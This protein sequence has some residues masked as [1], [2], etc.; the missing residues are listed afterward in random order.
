VA[1]K[2]R[3]DRNVY[4]AAIERLRYVFAENDKVVVSFSGGKDST[5][6]AYLAIEVA[7]ELKRPFYLF[8]LDQE[9]EYSSTTNF[10]DTM[11]KHKWVIPLWFQVPCLLTNTSSMTQHVIDPWNPEKKNV[12]IRCQKQK[13]TTRIDW[14]VSGV[15][16]TF[17]DRQMYGFYGLV[18]CM[19]ALFKE[20]SSVAQVL[21][22]RADESLDRFRAVTKNPGIPGVPWST[23]GHHHVKFYP[24]YDWQFRDVW[25]Y[26]G[27]NGLPYNKMYDY[28]YL[29]GYSSSRMRLSN[30]LHEKAY[31]CIADLQEFEPK[32]YDKMIDRCMGI[33]TA[34]EY[35]GRGGAIYHA[36][37]LPVRFASWVEYRD[38]LLDT[39]PNQEHAA[40]FRQ[41]FDKQHQNDYVVRQQ[42]NRVLIYDIHN[43]KKINN[44][45]HD[46]EEKARE[47]WMETF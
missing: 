43:F 2:F 25:I 35:A 46:P 6:L 16:Y 12:W 1:K 42:V 11:M 40:A 15:P 7:E 26:L 38:Y 17:A 45:E 34:Q 24:I 28:F 4:E 32:L 31:E 5:V 10:V 22:L 13:A 30:L 23:K 29:K 41:R 19:E 44:Y 21:G 18:Q 39:L 37:K 9:I 47:R 3:N 14:D 20:S 8:Y 33:A 36:T 27:R